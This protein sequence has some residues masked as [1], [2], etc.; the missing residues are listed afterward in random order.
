M[1]VVPALAMREK[2][3]ARQIRCLH[4]SARYGPVT[5]SRIVSKIGND[6]MAGYAHCNPHEYA[7]DDP[8][9]TA[10]SVKDC[11]QCELVQRP[12]PFHESIPWVLSKLRLY[13][14]ARRVGEP[15]SAMQLPEGINP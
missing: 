7:P 10:K 1:V 8:V 5:W 2:P 12:G 15:K 3:Q 11:C 14:E 13:N 9:E 6:P 4:G